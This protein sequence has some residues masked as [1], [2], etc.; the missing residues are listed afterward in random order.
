MLEGLSRRED[1][2]GADKEP[3]LDELYAACHKIKC[4][5]MYLGEKSNNCKISSN[6]H[7]KYP[8]AVPD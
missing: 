4:E 1:W 2:G 3:S 8:I 7:K 6:H 5:H